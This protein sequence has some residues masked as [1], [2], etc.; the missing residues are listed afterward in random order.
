MADEGSTD[1]MTGAGGS[2]PPPSGAPPRRRSVGGG[3]GDPGV[4]KTPIGKMI[5]ITLVGMAVLFGVG[6]GIGQFFQSSSSGTA[7]D[8]DTEPE[9]CVT[10]NVTPTP[11]P[12]DQIQV[13]VLNASAPAGSAAST[14]ETLGGVGFQIAD[15]GNGST[16]VTTAP[17]V[18]RYGPTSAE[19][20]KTL[21]AYL[22]GATEMQ[23][24]ADVVGLELIL[25]GPFEG[26]VDPA[27]AQAEL[28]VPIPS[29]SGPGCTPPA[30][31]AP[32]DPNAVPQPTPA[33]A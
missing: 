30:P 27:T 20:A 8:G 9:T 5:L 26:V 10:V 28:T 32:A 6:Y 33:A 18:I 22:A 23:E 17:A 15:V 4:K 1:Q 2:A 3:A 13:T 21:N 12:P 11:L 25:V 31:G 7:A 16:D 14:A 29:A 24:A 19:A